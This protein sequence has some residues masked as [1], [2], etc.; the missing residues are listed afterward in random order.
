MCWISLQLSQQYSENSSCYFMK[1]IA[2]PLH[3]KSISST[4]FSTI[5]EFPDM[6]LNQIF[7]Y[8]NQKWP[9]WT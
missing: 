7:H 2:Q 1:T 5:H 3:H 9:E 8:H 4:D 6:L